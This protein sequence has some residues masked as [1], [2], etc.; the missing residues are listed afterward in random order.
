MQGYLAYVIIGHASQVIPE[1]QMDLLTDLFFTIA[2]IGL[3][4]FSIWLFV[5]EP[6]GDIH[7]L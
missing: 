7:N 3:I 4:G 5:F 2:G 6:R 1:L